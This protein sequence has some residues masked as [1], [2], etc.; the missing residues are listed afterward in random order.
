MTRV[1]PPF[2]SRAA[3]GVRAL[4]P[5][6]PGMPIDE[7]QRRLGVRDVVKLASNENPLGASPQV[8]AA[9]SAFL[10]DG[11]L[12]L[13]PDGGGFRLRRRL[14]EFHDIEPER[15]TLGNG[16]NDILEFV[17]RAFLAPGRAAMFSDYAFAVYPI[18][19][20]A[21]GARAVVVPARPANDA[22]PYGHDLEAFAAALTDDVSTIFIANPN[23]PTG[24]WLSPAALEAFLE[25]VPPQTVVLLD[26]AYREY[27]PAADQPDSRAL[28]ER[29]PNLIVTRTFSKVHGLAGL[30]A[31]YGLSHPD[32][33]DLLNHVRQPFNMNVMA[34]LAAEVALD[35]PAHVRHSVELCWNEM[36]RMQQALRERGL[37]WLPSQANFL[38]IDFARDAAPLHHGLL[39]Q[40]IILRPMGSYGL[41]NYLRA[42]IGTA[43]QNDRLLTALDAVLA[44][45][46]V[47][48]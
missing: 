5:Y 4:E 22:M 28:L 40:G 26:E 37:R 24:T 41:P 7:L 34:L 1:T 6:S 43:A 38:T 32:M 47:A 39:E 31:G 15:I 10:A 25:R 42:T 2:H 8:R 44:R 20:Q 30:R 19:T 9:L 45:N 23:N 13:Y 17:G 36:Q 46:A 3:A 12:G 27:Q 16:S 11:D 48:S 33:A 21:Q 29:F 35:D 18:V 14:A